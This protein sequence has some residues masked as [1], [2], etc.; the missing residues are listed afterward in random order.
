MLVPIDITK[1]IAQK[2]TQRE[3]ICF[4]LPRLAGVKGVVNA[5]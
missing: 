1:L 2:F 5:R 4:N 3:L